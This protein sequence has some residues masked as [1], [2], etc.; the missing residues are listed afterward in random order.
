METIFLTGFI[1]SG[2]SAVSALL[3][4]RGIPVYD[5]DA[6][7]KAL[8]DESPSLVP[9]LEKALGMPLRTTD[10]KLDRKALAAVIFT[11][12]DARERVEALVYP[13]VLED[14][15]RWREAHDD[16]PFVVLES[17]IILS[18]PI[19]NGLAD[20][21]VLVT[22]PRKVR[23]Q[24]VMARDGLSE[25]EVIRRMDAQQMPMDGIDTVLQ[26]DGTPEQLRRAVDAVFFPKK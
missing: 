10:G 1:G 24:R 3:R 23:L 13:A 26:N 22:A 6:R 12:D 20:R 7:T 15:L 2:K 11:D 8:Y 5:S 4:E 18:K 25:E 19:F 16:A 14:F 21:V 17:A 9:A